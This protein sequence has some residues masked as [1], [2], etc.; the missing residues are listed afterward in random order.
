MD[1]LSITASIVAVLQATS[2]V[3]SVCYDY[4]AAIKGAPWEL[5]KVT[6]EL[7]GLR[8][9][10]ES[11]AKLSKAAA[12]ADPAAQSRLP[13]LEL[14]CDPKANGGP[15]AACLDEINGLKAKLSP[16]S[17]SGKDGSKR[18]ALIKA[19]GWPLKAKD[20]QR[21]LENI[22]RFKGTLNVALTSDLGYVLCCTVQCQ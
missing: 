9:V 17:W 12:D 18:Q 13:A 20:T 16:P 14:L 4:S 15:L 2:A 7:K 6:D 11:L 8:D 22:S 1:P 3:I 19:L 21:S 5:S 10:L